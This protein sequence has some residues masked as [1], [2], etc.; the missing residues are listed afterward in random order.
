MWVSD[1]ILA[2]KGYWVSMMLLKQ[3]WDNPSTTIF[4]NYYIYFLIQLEYEYTVYEMWI[5]EM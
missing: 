4:W 1:F 3:N 5:Y 2:Q